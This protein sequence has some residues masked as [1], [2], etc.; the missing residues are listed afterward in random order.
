MENEIKSRNNAISISKIKQKITANP[1]IV[2]MK[3]SCHVQMTRP[4]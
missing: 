1:P 3:N 2:N 4:R